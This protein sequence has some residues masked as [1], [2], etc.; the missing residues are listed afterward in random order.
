MRHLMCLVVLATAAVAIGCGSPALDGTVAVNGTVT[1]KGQPV[2]GAT[3]MFMPDGD[4][5]A[6]SGM[7]DA[8]GRFQLT[9]LTP[10]DGA[11]PGNY[12]VTVSKTEITATRPS[13]DAPP[14]TENPQWPPLTTAELL[15]VKYKL[16]DT[17]GLTAEVASGATNDFPFDLVD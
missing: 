3:V 13:G 7:T 16:A 4:R 17:S 11:M 9:T 14:P 2:E 1:Y 8:S 5:R 15:P 12:K 10:E 6:A